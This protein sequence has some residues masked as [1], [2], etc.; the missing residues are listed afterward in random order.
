MRFAWLILV[1]LMVPG[2][3]TTAQELVRCSER[4]TQVL[5]PRSRMGFC[6]ELVYHEQNAGEMA[7]TALA[8]TSDGTL[9]AT[10]PLY[11][12]LLILKD[13]DGD[14]LPDS[15]QLIAENLSLPNTLTVHDDVVYIAGGNA[16]YRWQN[17]TLTTLIDDLPTGT[18]VWNGGIVVYE[19]RLIVGVGAPCN[20][21]NFDTQTYGLLLSFA[22]DGSDRQI[23]ATGLRQPTALGVYDGQLW[24]GDSAPYG[25]SVMARDE[26]QVVVQGADYGFPRCTDSAI[27]YDATTNNDCGTVI[28]PDY[29]FKPFAMP[30]SVLEYTGEAFAD[31]QGKLLLLLAGTPNRSDPSGFELIAFTPM[32]ERDQ[33]EFDTL[34]PYDLSISYNVEYTYGTMRQGAGHYFNGDSEMLTRRGA[35]FYPHHPLSIA[36]SPEGWIYIAVSWGKIYV[37]RPV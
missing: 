6:M 35:G 8:F 18:G 25:T 5:L 12:Q 15:P 4:P 22:L 33:T 19:G 13:T 30:Y 9:F 24:V 16:V 7:F 2:L 23:M 34:V 28:P 31:L 37:L 17:N 32:T 11:G 3:P 14:F 1:W 21:C 36:I 27:A 29:A 10:R 26:L 20:W